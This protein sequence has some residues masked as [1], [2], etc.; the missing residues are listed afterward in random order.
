MK[1]VISLISDFGDKFAET[2]I[3]LVIHG[4][5]PEIKFVVGERWITPFSIIEGAFIL[6]KL[7]PFTPTGSVHIAVVDPGVGS[8]RKG[9]IIKT[10]N[11]W[12]IGPDNGLLYQAAAQDG[13]EAAYTVDESKVGSLSNT[14]HGRDIFAKVAAYISAGRPLKE[15]AKKYPVKKIIQLH[16]QKNQVVNIDPYGNIKLGNGPNGYKPGD[17]LTIKHKRKTITAP[18]VKTFADVKPGEFLIYH[19]SHQTLEIA[20]NL[21]PAAKELGVKVGDILQI[22]VKV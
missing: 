8:D 18:F 22:N 9:L 12:F 20:V 21:E 1:P 13:I 14:F 19:G 10:K 7:Y 6:S 4:I 16:F 2:Q 3:E 11:Y 5:N 17:T 15:F